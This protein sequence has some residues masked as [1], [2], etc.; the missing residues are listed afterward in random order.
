MW[1]I[2]LVPDESIKFD[3]SRDLKNWP[4]RSGN[5]FEFPKN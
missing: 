5:I 2:G 3:A 1:P 4:C